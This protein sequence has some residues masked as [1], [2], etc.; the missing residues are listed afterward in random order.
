[1]ETNLGL[2]QDLNFITEG[3]KF[4]GRFSYDAYNYHEISRLR[5]PELYKAEPNRDNHGDLVLRRVAEATS[6]EQS[7]VSN[8]NRRY[9]GEINLSYDRLF[10]EKHRVG[11]LFFFYAQSKSDAF[12]SENSTEN[13]FKAVPYRNAAFSAGLL[14]PMTNVILPN[15]ISDIPVLK[16]S[17]KIS[18]SVFFRLWLSDGWCPMRNLLKT[19]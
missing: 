8:G 6:M 13:V 16:T 12:N 10:G 18:A 5:Q 3:L 7:T 11:A 9:Y 17:K 15:L 1:M 19:M 2:R 4:Y 14:M